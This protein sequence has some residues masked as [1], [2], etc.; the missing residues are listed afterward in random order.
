MVKK[1]YYYSQN[2]NI[3][4]KHVRSHM[5]EPDK[6]DPTYKIWYGNDKADKLAVSAAESI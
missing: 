2:G 1:L 3:V 4:F 6:D 5:K